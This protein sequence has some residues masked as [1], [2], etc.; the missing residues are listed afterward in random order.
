MGG[1]LKA[2]ALE[3]KMFLSEMIGNIEEDVPNDL[4]KPTVRSG[5]NA[6]GL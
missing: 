5:A 2:I 4:G 6:S 1:Y 3:K